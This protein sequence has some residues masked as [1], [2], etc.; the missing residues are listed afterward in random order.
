MSPAAPRCAGPLQTWAGDPRAQVPSA[1][2]IRPPRSRRRG[3]RTARRSG[4]PA[5]TRSSRCR[6]A[7]RRA[8]R[9]C[10]ARDRSRRAAPRARGARSPAAGSLVL[11][12]Q[13]VDEGLEIVRRGAPRK[14]TPVHEEARRSPHTERLAFLYARLDPRGVALPVHAGVILVEV[15]PDGPPEVAEQRARILPRLRPLVVV[16]QLVVHL[17][18][19]ALLSGALGG[20]RRIAGVLVR[21]QRKVAKAPPQLPGGDQLL[22]D[23]GHLHRRKRRAE[24][25]L[26]VRI[27]RDLDRRGVRPQRVDR[28]SVV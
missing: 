10:R 25:T 8:R 20:H 18:E 21:G 1:P 3:C 22:A 28:K 7:A 16:E 17:P 5:R 14:R 12:G 27:L 15:E 23:D 2:R 13:A 4:S 6:T 11:L 24:R 19:L 9:S 26:E